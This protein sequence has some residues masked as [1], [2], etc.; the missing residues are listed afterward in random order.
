VLHALTQ[1][2]TP[3]HQGKAPDWPEWWPWAIGSPTHHF[4]GRLIDQTGSFN[5]GLAIGRIAAAG[6]VCVPLGILEPAKAE[7]RGGE[8]LD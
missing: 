4:F 8:W 5:L 2:L 7:N 3:I 6:G 1:E